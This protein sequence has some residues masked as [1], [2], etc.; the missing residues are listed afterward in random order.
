MRE[1]GNYAR[2][3]ELLAVAGQS[4]DLTDQV[5]KLREQLVRVARPKR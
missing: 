2:A 5:T 4:P 3:E 1:F